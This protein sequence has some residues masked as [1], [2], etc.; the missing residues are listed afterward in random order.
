MARGQNDIDA[1]LEALERK[2]SQFGG[3]ARVSGVHAVVHSRPTSQPWS[4]TTGSFI[5]K[6]AWGIACIGAACGANMALNNAPE[7]VQPTAIESVVVTPAF[8]EKQ[9]DTTGWRSAKFNELRKNLNYVE[10]TVGKQKH[11]VLDIA[12]RI[13]LVKAAAEN[14]KLAECNLNSND[15][16]GIIHAE[17]GWIARSGMGANHVKSEGLAQF[18]PNTAKAFG[19]DNPN[20]VVQAVFGAA[21]VM[22]E[23]GL[24]ARS[25]LNRELKHKNFSTQ[26]KNKIFHAYISAGYNLSSDARNDLTAETIENA[27]IPTQLHIKNTEQGTKIAASIEKNI[28][29]SAVS[30]QHVVTEEH[31]PHSRPRI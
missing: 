20:D 21:W 12:S 3:S 2:L 9:E 6:M 8:V 1:T 16:Y 30:F 14:A 25:K 29:S 7:P 10:I 13:A 11:T 28:E 22:K 4:Q 27:P 26:Q 18:E 15:L 31:R 5:R 19:I 24:W 17:T 23:V